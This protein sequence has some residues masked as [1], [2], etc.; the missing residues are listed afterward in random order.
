MRLFLVYERKF[1]EGD[2]AT[3]QCESCPTIEVIWAN[4]GVQA[5]KKYPLAISTSD[6]GCVSR[7]ATSVVQNKCNGKTWCSFAVQRS[8]FLQSTCTKNTIL[9]VRFKCNGKIPGIF[10]SSFGYSLTEFIVRCKSTSLYILAH[11]AQDYRT[12]KIS[13]A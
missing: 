1:S 10:A 6:K 5:T 11:P 9:L 8:E 3:F 4:Y 7:S 13:Y 12:H 2:K